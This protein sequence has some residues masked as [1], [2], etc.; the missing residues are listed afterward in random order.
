MTTIGLSTARVAY[1]ANP[2][3]GAAP[4]AAAATT[5]AFKG[6][7]LG[8]SAANA[9]GGFAKGT[10]YLLVLG[11]EKPSEEFSGVRMR[12]LETVEE[13]VRADNAAIG[14]GVRSREEWEGF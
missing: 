14:F 2:G 11:S 7:A 8:H 9:D 4:T 13:E 1:R 6:A 5:E 3:A 12:V 10:P